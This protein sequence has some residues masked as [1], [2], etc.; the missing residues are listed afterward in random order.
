MGRNGRHLDNE[1]DPI[2]DV[3]DGTEHDDEALDD[4]PEDE[5][6]DGEVDDDEV[7]DGE[8][9]DDE[10]DDVDGDD[11]GDDVDGDEEVKAGSDVDEADDGDQGDHDTA[12]ADEAGQAADAADAARATVADKGAAEAA[13]EVEPEPEPE[14]PSA[15][16][17]ALAAARARA[18][19]NPKMKWYV[20]HTYSGFEN[21]AKK[22]LEERMRLEGLEEFFGEVLV[23]Q[24]TV[25]ELIGGR[26]RR[27]NRKHFPGYM[28]VQMELNKESWHLVKSTPKITG[29]VGNAQNPMPIRAR[30]VERLRKLS[31]GTVTVKP[32]VQYYEGETVRVIE[33]PFASFNGTVEEVKDEKQ[34]LRVLVSI[35]GRSTPV[36][37]DFHQVEKTVK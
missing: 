17:A 37:L 27:T 16:E 1:D 5:V 33:G 28:I 22:S 25:A 30:E 4:Q 29:F 13:E 11:E 36:E 9:D 8:A 15:E 10:G 32:K 3:E 23:P 35:F 19:A 31:E 2:D 6:D 18:A 34:K 26:T 21:K 12:D 20:V 14:P 7:E 24:E